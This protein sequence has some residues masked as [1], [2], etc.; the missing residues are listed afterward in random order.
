[1][2]A[3]A[4]STR[5]TLRTELRRILLELARQEDDRAA[6]RAARQPY[7]APCPP[8]VVGHR[9]AALALR[10]EADLL[11]SVAETQVQRREVSDR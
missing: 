4:A 6:A 11:I 3:V 9:L 10:D 7:W 8:T 2:T 5:E 1:M